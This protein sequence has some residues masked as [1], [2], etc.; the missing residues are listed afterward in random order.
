MGGDGQSSLR[1]GKWGTA[2]WTS[3]GFRAYFRQDYVFCKD[4]VALT[5]IAIAKAAPDYEAGKVLNGFLANF[6]SAEND[7]FPGR[8]PRPGRHAG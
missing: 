2:L 6:L 3:P 5:A 7:L 1:P 8:L 4:L